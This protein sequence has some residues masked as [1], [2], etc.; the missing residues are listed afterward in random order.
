MVPLQIVPVCMRQPTIP[1]LYI[2][3]TGTTPRSATLADPI[4]AKQLHRHH[5]NRHN[6]ATTTKYCTY[7]HEQF[8]VVT[9]ASLHAMRQGRGSEATEPICMP[10]RQKSLSIHQLQQYMQQQCS[11][12]IN[13]C[14]LYVEYRGSYRQYDY[15]EE[16][17]P[18]RQCATSPKQRPVQQEPYAVPSQARRRTSHRVMVRLIAK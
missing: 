16:K 15:T 1:A 11:S 14:L 13:C 18:M 5:R 3:G 6:G 9:R 4:C 8:K 10:S 12:S 17:R 7:I 2:A